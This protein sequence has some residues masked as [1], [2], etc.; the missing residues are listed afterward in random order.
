[1]KQTWPSLWKQNR[2]RSVGGVALAVGTVLCGVGL[3]AASGYLI[4]RAAAQP[5]ILSLIL[6]IIAVR[7]F[8]IARAGVRYAERLVTHEVTLRYL[9]HLR[10]WLF[11]RLHPLVPSRRLPF[12]TGE[13]LS[14][15]VGDIDRMQD[16]Y[17]RVMLPAL[18]AIV[19]AMITAG[20]LAGLSLSAAG[21]YLLMFALG[22]GATA[23]SVIWA[24]RLRS[25]ASLVNQRSNIKQWLVDRLQG[26]R[27]LQM[28][29]RQSEA[30]KYFEQRE[31]KLREAQ[32]RE[33]RAQ[34][35][36]EAIGQLGG[37][38]AMLATFLV[39]AGPVQQGLLEGP[40]LVFAVLAVWS[41]LEILAPLGSSVRLRP[42]VEKAQNELKK[43]GNR[44]AD[45]STKAQNT[46]LP[47]QINLQFEKV[48]FSYGEHSV[49]D[50]LS[51]E[52]AEGEKVAVVGPSGAG[53][54]TV[55]RLLMRF[56]DP[57]HGDIKVGGI[58]L[59]EIDPDT[60]R[61][62]V[63]MVDQH[64]Y[65]FDRTLRQNLLLAD[66]DVREGRLWEVLEAAGLKELVQSWPD[67]L[68]TPMGE[69]GMRLSG[70][71]RRRVGLARALLKDAPVWL[72]DEPTSHL[73]SL[74][75]RKLLDTLHRLS[76]DKTMLLITHRLVDMEQMDRI[77]VLKDG[78]IQQYGTH[79]EMQQQEGWYQTMMQFQ[80]ELIQV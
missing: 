58:P 73:D 54:S 36:E 4:T 43:W 45:I 12:R 8:S 28:L 48:S 20:G 67:G 44:A 65:L 55:A 2:W 79:D 29:G 32:K 80:Q 15:L 18:V 22:A 71:E 7:F 25:G 76:R 37:H 14:R 23:Y 26:V 57:E 17:L 64:A 74:S 62:H 75:E 13:L 46:R 77:I 34:G 59:R 33:A 40:W 50:N 72:L 19:V 61:R 1:M 51:F 70:G 60:W 10:T 5:P 47:N 11:S 27:D 24:D 30:K 16:R 21:T 38:A 49:L 63:A 52:V 42:T 66:P 3:M 6:W 56:F 9:R 35:A 53:K 41:S 78:K 68:D 69:H 31:Q 39:L